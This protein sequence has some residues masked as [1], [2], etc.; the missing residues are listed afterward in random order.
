LPDFIIRFAND[1]HRHLILET[2]GFDELEDVKRAAADRWI[3]AVNAEG[4]FGVWEYGVA[5]KVS[6]V[7]QLI[8]KVARI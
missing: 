8:S 2:K 6:E 4:S 1:P 3:R 5:K 7:P